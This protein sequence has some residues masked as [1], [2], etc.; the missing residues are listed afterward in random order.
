[1]ILFKDDFDRF[2]TAMIDMETTN[3]S[4]LKMAELYR[5][6]G[7]ENNAFH[8]TLLQ[9][10][11]QGVDPYDPN[12]T[13]DIKLKIIQECKWNPW[14]LF[15]E[16]M[17]V[18]SQS[19]GTPVRFRANR[20]NIALI[21]AFF[22]HIMFFLIQPRQTGKS[23]STDCL[24]IALIF[25]LAASTKIN[26]ITKDNKLRMANVDRLKA[27][28]DLLPPYLWV[29]DKND[30]DNSHEITYLSKKN[31]YGTA[32]AQSSESNATNVGRGS[33]API[34]HI[35]EAPFIKFIGTILPAM[36]AAG[37]AARDEARLNNQPY[38]T[39]ITTTAGKIDDRDGGFVYEI[40]MEA[41]IWDEMYLDL[42]NHE[43][44]I[45]VLKKAC[46][47]EDGSVA[48]NGTFSHTQLGFSN[49]W[50]RNAL[51]ES[52]SRGQDADRDFFNRWTRGTQRSPLSVEMNKR[53]ADS[54]EEAVHMEI[55]EELY[56]L[57]WYID[58]EAIETYM[59]QN[60]VILGLDT[61]E[62]IGRDAISLVGV[63]SLDGGTVLSAD[64]NE[65]NL[66]MFGKF[67]AHLLIK[68]TNTVL[69]I[70][71]KSTGQ[72]IVDALILTMLAEGVDPFRRI[73][74]VI[75]QQKDER[76]SDFAEINRT[77]ERRDQ[78][79]YVAHKKAFGFVT[80]GATRE[81]LYGR[82]LQNA[83]KSS[84]KLV[85]DRTLA[86]QIRGLVVKNGRIDHTAS[87]NDDAVIAWLLAHWFLMF[88]KNLSF[89]GIPDSA[90]LTMVGADELDEDPTAKRQKQEQ[91]KLR[92]DIQEIQD[93]LATSNDSFKIAVN[94]QKLRMLVRKLNT[95]G[96][97]TLNYDSMVREAKEK[98][99][100]QRT[101]TAAARREVSGSGRSVVPSWWGRR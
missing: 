46:R 55:T 4:F 84:G 32:V 33:T 49:E 36:L 99:M 91:V 81:L 47:S 88:G 25:I 75:V 9:R 43:H 64:I 76:P 66:I 1:M 40:L 72:M 12:L 56:S 15:R 89:Y 48:I 38:G 98:R 96:V 44:L 100:V 65:T 13:A 19:G 27:I 6:M 61:S 7:I 29:L 8:L 37:S 58:E 45:K 85:K 35:D 11:L 79:C 83:A 57:R 77:L 94:E 20:G 42:D 92:E 51:A 39:I 23:V 97:E 73:Y 67:L 31:V 24:M 69:V 10:E 82:V 2:P 80:T 3:K 95:S 74:N 70:E 14:Y 87:G 93:V 68:Y 34:A 18:P 54:E 16:V 22:N 5:R 17:R 30:A 63:N 21:W 50:L 62:A 71:R 28:R 101:Q 59:Q 60:Y 78:S 53:I 52:K 90:V 86:Q 26:M 41:A